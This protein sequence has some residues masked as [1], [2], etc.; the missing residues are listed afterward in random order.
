LEI[1]CGKDGYYSSRRG[2]SEFNYTLG[3]DIISPDSQNPVLF[4]LYKKGSPVPLIQTHF[5][6]GIGQRVRLHNDGTPTELSLLSAQETPE[7]SGQLR[8]EFWQDNS[9]KRAVTFNWKFRVSV[10]GGGLLP[11]DQEFAFEAP[12]NGYTSDAVVD[13]PASATN[14]TDDFRV[15]YYVHLSDGNF[16]CVDIYLLADNGI[17]TVH[18]VINPTGSRNLEPAN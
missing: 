15:K 17:F 8:L 13:M 11:S 10:P 1:S 18:S 4:R 2:P 9:S 5:P 7:G 3:P 12:D 6:I 14:W 16:A